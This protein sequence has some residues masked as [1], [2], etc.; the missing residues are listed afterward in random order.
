[1]NLENIEDGD[2]QT[3]AGETSARA[4][5]T[6]DHEPPTA[7]EIQLWLVSRVAELTAVDA[8]EVDIAEPFA[9]FGLDSIAAAGLSGDLEDWLNR[10][11]PPTLIWDYP[12]IELLAQHLAGD[13]D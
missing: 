6:L 12:T 5:A 13:S 10:R 4:A 7:E 9:R 3:G 11:L 2:L 8:D 1:M